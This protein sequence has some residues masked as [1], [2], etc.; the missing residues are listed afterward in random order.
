MK[1]S[2]QNTNMIRDIFHR[3]FIRRHFWRRATFSEIAELYTSRLLRMLALNLAASFMSIYLYQQGFSVIFI[4]LFW[5]GVFGLKALL[6]IPAARIVAWFGAKHAILLSNI[7]YIPSMI[8]FSLVSEYGGGLLAIV[9]VLQAFSSVLYTV[10]YNVDFSKVK[11]VEHA[12]KEIAYMNIVEKFTTG[13]SP[14]IGG[15]LAFFVGPEIVLVITAVLFAIA[16]VPL[17]RTAEPERP[18]QKLKLTA[19]PRRL[20]RDISLA[21]WSY[22]FDVFTSGTAWSLYIAIFI[23]GIGTGDEVYLANGILLSVVLLAALVASYVFGRLIDNRRGKELMRVAIVANALTHVTRPSVLSL[24]NVA[25]LNV[26]NETATTGYTMAYNRA[27]F[28]NADL[29]G[30]RV[31]Y[32]GV[33]DTI[34]NAGASMA[35]ATLAL[36][37]FWLGEQLGLESFFYVTAGVVLLILTARFPMFRR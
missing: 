4:A 27:L 26:A 5:S 15:I 34:A 13:L 3:L 9:A 8:T 29:S 11:S 14:L 22:G 37:A 17:L 33:M 23:I 36:L 7:V 31:A 30:H 18:R 19:V 1:Q 6:A 32:L 10:A 2:G 16:A 25:A 28:D 12:G 21:H 20:I 35:A 24:F